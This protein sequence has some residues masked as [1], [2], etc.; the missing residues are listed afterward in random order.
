MDVWHLGV[1]CRASE[2][3]IVATILIAIH[4]TMLAL[5]VSPPQ[6]IACERCRTLGTGDRR[7]GLPFMQL[8]MPLQVLLWGV[9]ACMSLK[10]EF[11]SRRTSLVKR[12]EHV[13]H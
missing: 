5:H 7:L 9:S 4:L 11:C 3:L 2:R 8:E 13:E 1:L 6:I 10:G 12:L